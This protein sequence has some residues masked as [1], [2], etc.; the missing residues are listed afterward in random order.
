MASRISAGKTDHW[1]K[2]ARVTK[3]DGQSR[4]GLMVSELNYNSAMMHVRLVLI[5]KWSSRFYPKSIEVM[6]Q[7]FFF[8]RCKCGNCHLDLLQNA[9]KCQCC[10]EIPQQ[11]VSSLWSELYSKLRHPS[12]RVLPSVS[13]QV[14]FTF[15]CRQIQGSRWDKVQADGHRNWVSCKNWSWAVTVYTPRG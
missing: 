13:E 8:F 11:Q 9:N 3:P 15:C 5:Q 14:V 12:S 2:G 10:Q 6:I 7:A 1:S 4:E